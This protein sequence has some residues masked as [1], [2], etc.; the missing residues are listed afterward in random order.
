MP[1]ERTLLSLL[2]D[3]QLAFDGDPTVAISG[4]SYD[5]RKVDPGFVFVA[6]SGF[7][8]DGLKFAPE[9]LERGAVAVVAERGRPGETA[10]FSPACWATV[11]SSRRALATMACNWYHDP[12][13]HMAVVGI[14]GTNGKTTVTALLD[15]MLHSGGRVGRWSTTEVRIGDESYPTPR[16][17]PESLELQQALA[18]MRDVGCWAATIEVSS[19]ALRLARVAGT[20]FAA[21]A[22]TN[23]SP[24][25]LDFHADMDDYL[26]AKASLF[27]SLGPDVPAVINFSDPVADKLAASTS[28]RVIG[29]A[30]Q[31]DHSSPGCDYVITANEPRA[32]GSLVRLHTPCGPLQ[33]PTPLFG[34]ANA[35]NI[36]A[37]A[38]TAME[39]GI[40]PKAVAEAVASFGGEPGRL[41]TIDRGQPF[42]VLVDFAHTPAA[43][44]AAIEAAAS[45]TPDGRLI[46][47]FGAGGDKD[48]S[49]R[50][51][52]GRVAAEG[53]DTAIVT[54]DNPRS[55]DPLEIIAEVVAGI[56]QEL[57][58]KVHIEVDRHCAIHHAIGIAA[59]GDCV[60]LAGKGHETEQVFADRVVP[61]DDTEVAVAA[62]RSRAA[63]EET[64]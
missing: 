53:A 31:H 62:I 6:I 21:A 42:R 49:K 25:H 52:M 58:S 56:P 37:A 43:L 47:V 23:L 9:A 46:V 17:T 29:Y 41:Q 39:L 15:A 63:R 55:E 7:V 16:T 57:R 13:H 19:H 48:R 59:A 10:K 33:L 18:R 38:A 11:S 28:G 64:G 61:F 8:H 54:S 2:D 12:S 32:N 14:T 40:A 50:P 34:R 26:D 51:T 22:F 5:S 20:R 44:E 36:A 3:P 4:V 35:E 24:D 1:A 45:S 60:L 30:W 27:A